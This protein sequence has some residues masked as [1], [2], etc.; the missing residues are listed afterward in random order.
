MRYFFAGFLQHGMRDNPLH[1]SNPCKFG[2]L[3]P[4]FTKA[5]DTVSVPA[6]RNHGLSNL[7]APRQKYAA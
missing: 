3:E 5:A 7:Q 2:W 6:L 1:K 4:A